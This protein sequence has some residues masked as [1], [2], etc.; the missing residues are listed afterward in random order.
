MVSDASSVP[1]HARPDDQAR[2]AQLAMPLAPGVRLGPYEILA[3]LGAGG[4]GEVYRARDTRLRREVAV[5]VLPASFS[6]D[7]DRLR[8]FEQEA[9]A[10]SALNHPNILTIHD[11]GSEA[12]APYV[13]FELLEGETLRE[14]IK[15][16]AMPEAMAVDHGVQIAN[17]M[18]AAHEKGIV[19]RDLKP[20]NIFVTRS[21]L[22]KILDFGLAKLTQ[23]DASGEPASEVAT[24]TAETEPGVVLGTVGYMSPEQVKGQAVDPRS[25][26]FSL[27]AVLYEMLAGRRAFS[28]SSSAE[29]LSAILRDEPAPLSRESL[30]SPLERVVRRCLEKSPDARFQSAR[31]L[32]FALR[33]SSGRR[34]ATIAARPAAAVVRKTLAARRRGRPGARGRRRLGARR[35]DGF[36]SASSEPARAGG[37]ARSPCC[38]SRTSRAIP[39]RT[40]SPTA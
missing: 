20:E 39:G 37:C 36:A 1:R 31:D 4:M 9:L 10:A 16:G 14:R 40:T 19:H 3:P 23:P 22:V 28:G 32:A 25:D 33:E 6:Q 5:K 38:R 27:G 26:L 12:G 11:I 15:A 18:A 2:I 30:P 8:R 29:T 21:G 7:P 13:V 24:F 17:G 34:G 35:L